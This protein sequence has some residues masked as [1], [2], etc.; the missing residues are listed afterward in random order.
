MKTWGCLFILYVAFSSSKEVFSLFSIQ[1]N[2][3]LWTSNIKGRRLKHFFKNNNAT[4][5][6]ITFQASSDS[7]YSKLFKPWL[8]DI[9]VLSILVFFTSFVVNMA[10]LVQLLLGRFVQTHT[11][12]LLRFFYYLL[13]L[14]FEKV[15]FLRR[16]FYTKIGENCPSG[17]REEVKTQ[18]KR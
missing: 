15:F 8:H 5:C 18:D 12:F 9:T 17:Y 6:K 7:V 10:F 13:Y 1:C 14:P 16:M 3:E 2:V 4:I 11:L